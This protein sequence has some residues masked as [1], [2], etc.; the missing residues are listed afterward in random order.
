MSS[1]QQ[2]PDS[3]GM[4]GDGASGSNDTKGDGRRHQQDWAQANDWE[5]HREHITELYRDQGLHLRQVQAIMSERYH[6]HASQRMYKT[7]ISKWA[8]DKNLKA[9]E[10]AAI[11]R[12]QQSR[13]ALGKASKFAIRGRDIDFARVEQYLKRDPSLLKKAQKADDANA[14][15]PDAIFG[16][17][18]AAGITCRTPSP[19]PSP[20]PSS[21]TDHQQQRHPHYSH[22]PPHQQQQGFPESL[23]LHDSH[24]HDYN[25]QQ[26]QQPHAVTRSHSSLLP[27]S[28]V[29]AVAPH[30]MLSRP[31]MA[32]TDAPFMALPAATSSAPSSTSSLPMSTTACLPYMPLHPALRPHMGDSATPLGSYGPE[33]LANPPTLLSHDD[34]LMT[35]GMSHNT[36]TTTAAPFHQVASYASPTSPYSTAAMNAN[37]GKADLAQLM[38]DY[39]RS[40]LQQGMWVPRGQSETSAFPYTYVSMKRVRPLANYPVTRASPLTPGVFPNG[41][42]AERLAA[43]SHVVHQLRK[44]LSRGILN[45]TFERV[46]ASMDMLGQQLDAEDPALLF[47]LL[48]HSI[49]FGTAAAA[50]P[51]PHIAFEIRQLAKMLCTHVQSLARIML[52]EAHPI[53]RIF[54]QLFADSDS[55]DS[56]DCYCHS[57]IYDRAHLEA[58]LAPMRALQEA[59]A[60]H[61]RKVVDSTAAAQCQRMAHLLRRAP[62]G[63]LVVLDNTVGLAAPSDVNDVIA[64]LLA[65]NNLHTQLHCFITYLDY[66]VDRSPQTYRELAAQAA[67]TKHWITST[68]PE[69]GIEHA[70]SSTAASAA[71]STYRLQRGGIPASMPDM[72]AAATAAAVSMQSPLSLS[73]TS[74]PSS[75]ASPGSTPSHLSSAMPMTFLPGPMV[76]ATASS[77][78][79]ISPPLSSMTTP[80][81]V[82]TGSM[83]TSSGGHH[84]MNAQQQQ[85]QQLSWQHQSAY[86]PVPPFYD[87]RNLMECM[88]NSDSSAV[89]P[90]TLDGNA[91]AAA[92]IGGSGHEPGSVTWKLG[93]GV[94]MNWSG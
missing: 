85:H 56:G 61:D 46:H 53:S 25:H 63:R 20:S 69:N 55:R 31:S 83:I 30:A 90:E 51:N 75:T 35:G 65:S 72:M 94:H 2:S 70:G 67:Q 62:G 92:A 33:T 76:P 84:Q 23:Q 77:S 18:D 74:T 48:F 47:H 41:D 58:L 9:A 88:G 57:R 71:A 93:D 86:P 37:T 87:D 14:S 32:I 60:A 40:A 7:R 36:D 89:A 1:G 80:R 27:P 29:P 17:I 44:L 52:G 6:F 50:A 22:H 79:S 24:H 16:H 19:T 81:T 66:L 4:A 42:S 54:C 21:P 38:R 43:W 45:Q 34:I 28:S 78:S 15:P 26:Q 8:I 10:V 5:L 68:P 73:A 3:T 39:T 49:A 64:R 11:L 12:M 59:L 82:I 13:A 91:T